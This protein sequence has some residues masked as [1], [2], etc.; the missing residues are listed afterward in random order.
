MVTRV[1]FVRRCEEGVQFL[2][3]ENS[4]YTDGQKIKVGDG[5]F[6]CASSSIP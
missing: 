5:V 6:S 2:K 3:G 1:T 4:K